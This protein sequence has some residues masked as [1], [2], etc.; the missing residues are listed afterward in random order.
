MGLAVETIVFYLI[1]NEFDQIKKY[2]LI[3]LKN[4]LPSY[5]L[6]WSN[7]LANELKSMGVVSYLF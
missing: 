5:V 3:G 4:G 6:F 7:L 1:E 2:R